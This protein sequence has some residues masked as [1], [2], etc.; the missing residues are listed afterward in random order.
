MR[1]N[2]FSGLLVL[3]SL[4]AATSVQGQAGE[5]RPDYRNPALLT[6]RHVEDLLARMTLEEKV[7]QMMCLWKDKSRITDSQGRFDCSPSQ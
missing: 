3:C 1:I 5:V 4:L 2:R 6:A 7:A